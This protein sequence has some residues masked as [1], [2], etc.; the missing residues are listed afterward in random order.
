MKYFARI[1][2]PTFFFLTNCGNPNSSE[3]YLKFIKKGFNADRFKLENIVLAE[4]HIH[5][6]QNNNF[7]APL[8]QQLLNTRKELIYRKVP[9]SDSMIWSYALGINLVYLQYIQELKKEE[10][11]KS[12][13]DEIKQREIYFLKR[14]KE[15]LPAKK[16]RFGKTTFHSIIKQH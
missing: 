12:V 10:I 9:S 4:N 6:D 11:K 2:V 7:Y 13:V 14:I 3:A 15:K 5:K 8:M 1:F 16:S